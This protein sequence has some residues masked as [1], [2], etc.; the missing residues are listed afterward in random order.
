MRAHRKNNPLFALMKY[1]RVFRNLYIL[2]KLPPLIGAK[3]DT[4]RTLY[5]HIESPFRLDFTGFGHI[6][7]IKRKS[8]L[9]IEKLLLTYRST[10]VLTFSLCL[11]QIQ[12]TANVP[13]SLLRQRFMPFLPLFGY[14]QNCRC[15]IRHKIIP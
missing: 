8:F 6:G 9:Y 15:F 4:L 7:H 13:Q 14:H 3:P 11:L 2:G 5:G 10:T 12:I 1:K